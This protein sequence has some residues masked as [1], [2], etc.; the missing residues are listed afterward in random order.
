MFEKSFEP[1]PINRAKLATPI[2]ELASRPKTEYIPPVGPGS[3]SLPPV[4]DYRQLP[5]GLIPRFPRKK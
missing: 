4:G 5:P 2:I 1:Q 3:K